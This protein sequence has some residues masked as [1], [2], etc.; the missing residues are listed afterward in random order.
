MT[1]TIWGLTP[2][3]AFWGLMVPACLVGN[4]VSDTTATTATA[5]LPAWN[6]S[7]IS[8]LAGSQAGFS[9]WAEG[10][11]N[12]LALSLG[13]EGKAMQTVGSWAQTHELRLTFGLVKQDTLNVRKAEDVIRLSSSFRFQGDGFFRHFKP[14]LAASARSQFAPGYNFDKDPLGLGLRPPVKVSDLF[15]PATF[16]QTIGLTYDP[17]PWFKQRFGVGVKETVVM[18]ERIRPLYKVDPDKTSRLELGL[19]AHTEVDKELAENIRYRSEVGLFAAFNK[20]DVPDMM[21]ENL[22]AMKVNTWLGVN[23]DFAVLFDRDVSS[24][25]QMKEVFS[26]GVS[27]AVI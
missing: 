12:T 2:V 16:N 7:L 4:G 8:R 21:W 15:S 18:I 19:E 23:F 20:A 25:V 1:R 27:V 26:V 17:N 24:T 3:L 5:A 9:N 11:I 13:L 22:I 6:T 14:T 10:G